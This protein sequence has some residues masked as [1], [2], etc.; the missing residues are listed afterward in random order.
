[1]ANK[2]FNKIIEQYE[3]RLAYY[4][5]TMAWREHFFVHCS[6]ML[7]LEP[8]KKNNYIW[9]FVDVSGYSEKDIKGAEE[10]VNAIE[11]DYVE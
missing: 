6:D 11:Q 5:M 7:M 1:M 9:A 10:A 2:K 4:A 8:T 3:L